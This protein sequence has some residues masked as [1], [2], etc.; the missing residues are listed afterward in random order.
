[1][2]SQKEV[3]SNHRKY[4][5]PGNSNQHHPKKNAV[6]FS[7]TESFE[8]ILGKTIASAMISKYGD[9]KWSDKLNDLITKISIHLEKTLMKDFIKS[10]HDFINEASPNDNPKREIDVVDLNTNTKF[11]IVKT[12][13]PSTAKEEGCIIINLE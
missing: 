7:K 8:H 5:I 13:C 3:N 1:M 10:H 6:T 11:E 9:V 12:S 2:S 4:H